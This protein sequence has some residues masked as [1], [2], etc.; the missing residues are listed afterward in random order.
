MAGPSFEQLQKGMEDIAGSLG[1]SHQEAQG[2]ASAFHRFAGDALALRSQW[3]VLKIVGRSVSNAFKDASVAMHT[4][5]A[6]LRRTW[7]TQRGE[8]LESYTIGNINRAQARE[9]LS[10]MMLLKGLQ[11]AKV[12]LAEKFSNSSKLAFKFLEAAALQGGVLVSEMYALNTALIKSNS[13]LEQRNKLM[14]AGLDTSI[15]TGALFMDVLDAQRMLVDLGA[16]T[17][18]NYQQVLETVVLL[19]KGLGMSAQTAAHLAVI[20]QYQVGA[21]FE[22]VATTIGNIVNKTALAADEAGRMATELGK[23]MSMIRGQQ[24]GAIMPEVLKAVAKYEDSLKRIGGQAG[25]VADLVKKMSGP[26]GFGMAGMM[27]VV[28]PEILMTEQGVETMMKNLARMGDSLVGS[29]Q[30]WQRRLGLEVMAKMFNVSAEQANDLYLAAKRAHSGIQDEMS[31]RERYDEQTKTLVSGLQMLGSRMASLLESGLMPV[32]KLLSIFVGWLN[33]LT[34][35]MSSI[36]GLKDIFITLT[37]VAVPVAVVALLGLAKAIWKVAVASMAA[38]LGLDTSKA[39]LMDI[40]GGGMGF[41]GMKTG[42]YSLGMAMQ[43]LAG[44]LGRVGGFAAP[45]LTGPVSFGRMLGM[46]LA[47][48]LRLVLLNPIGLVITALASIGFT[49]WKIKGIDEAAEA[50]R[51]AASLKH[52]AG[53]LDL[54]ERRREQLY[55]R[56]RTGHFD[57]IQKK[58]DLALT[59]YGAHLVERGIFGPEAEKMMKAKA[60]ELAQDQRLAALTSSQFNQVMTAQNTQLFDSQL[61]TADAAR[62]AGDKMAETYKK[63]GELGREQRE[64]FARE[65]KLD[66]LSGKSLLDTWNYSATHIFGIDWWKTGN[67]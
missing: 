9:L 36:G 3:E 64:K 34:E 29:A 2:L 39:G 67:E 65:A 24:G 63:Q 14:Y 31:I 45:V 37:T 40:L 12:A 30:G 5:A 21:E 1:D 48:A 62:A 47:N 50:E 18:D 33:R 42:I 6:D 61:K 28:S 13:S 55:F 38:K 11:S 43:R 32:V 51:K 26:E 60:E 49:L 20:T 41:G 15:R 66:F 19:T 17:E 35:W 46:M 8:I 53:L 54:H 23:V 25:G 22:K 59:A 27:G 58:I 16:N 57:D 4:S 44:G 52:S 10:E 56:S 7:S